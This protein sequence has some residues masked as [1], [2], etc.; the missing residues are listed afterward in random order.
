MIDPVL[1]MDTRYAGVEEEAV[2]EDKE[3]RGIAVRRRAY[4]RARAYTAVGT[5]W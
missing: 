1:Q 3:A 5:R 2:S 4:T